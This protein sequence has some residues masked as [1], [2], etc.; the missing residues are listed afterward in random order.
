MSELELQES[1]FEK[2]FAAFIR[3]PDWIA[4]A[5]QPALDLLYERTLQ[6]VEANGGYSSV[7]AFEIVFRQLVQSG[8]ITKLRPVLNL[9]EEP[10]QAF[11]LT[12]EQYRS[13]PARTIVFKYQRDPAFKAAVDT[14]VAEGKI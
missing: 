10:G 4:Y 6:R 8:E 7:S 2:D 11:T 12:V 9:R 5:S 3:R 14:L 1:Q 13:I